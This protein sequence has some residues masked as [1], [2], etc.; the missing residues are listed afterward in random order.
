MWSR[1]ESEFYGPQ[2]PVHI[3]REAALKMKSFFGKELPINMDVL[4][5]GAILADVG[6]LLEYELDKEGNARQG[7]YGKYLRHP[8][9]GYRLQR[10]AVYP[11]KYAILLLPMPVRVTW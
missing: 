4:I 9:S 10:P 7:T 3:A 5:S 2:A 1:P 6:K 11:L 8:F